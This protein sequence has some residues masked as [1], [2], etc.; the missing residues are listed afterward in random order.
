MIKLKFISSLLQFI[1]AFLIPKESPP[2][3]ENKLIASI[4]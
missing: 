4:F 2:A 3:P 1:P